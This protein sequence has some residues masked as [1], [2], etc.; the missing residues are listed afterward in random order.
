[1]TNRNLTHN[2]SPQEE[3][4]SDRGQK[5]DEKH[6]EVGIDVPAESRLS[7]QED[8]RPQGNKPLP[9]DHEVG[10]APLCV[11]MHCQAVCIE[12]KLGVG[13]SLLFSPRTL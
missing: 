9:L 8:T 11:L 6:E 13:R 2:S 10:V 7:P 3:R 5:E 1:M 12:S 4:E